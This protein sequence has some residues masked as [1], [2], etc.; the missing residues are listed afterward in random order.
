MAFRG[1]SG[2]LPDVNAD[3]Q[4]LISGPVESDLE[5]AS[6]TKGNAYTWVST[7][8]TG[9]A[10]VEVISIKNTSE[11][12]CLIIDEII[13]GASAACIFTLFEVTSGT[14]AGTSITPKNI[15]TSSGNAAVHTSF[16]NAAVTG[17]LA[18]DVIAYDGVSAASEFTTLDTH[19]GVVLGQNGHYA[20]TASANATVY[21]TVIGHY[22]SVSK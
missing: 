17:S 15:N 4:M 18:G 19:G 13:V 11:A 7:F 8:A 10:D 20:I 5:Y 9:G 21:V 1:L 12:N 2:D 16:G 22:K 3:H 6:E 14:A